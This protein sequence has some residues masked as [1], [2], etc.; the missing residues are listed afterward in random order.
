VDMLVVV[1]LGNPGRKYEATRHNAGYLLADA[2]S[3]HC[4]IGLK[5]TSC[6]A[7][8]GRG[9]WRGCDL[10]I[11][12]P[13]TYMNLSGLAVL[14]L[15]RSFNCSPEHLMVACDDASLP[16]GQIRLRK[17]GSSGGQKGLQ[18]IIDQLGT[19]EFSRLRLGIGP[20]PERMP[21]EDYVLE[22]FTG[23]EMPVVEEMILRARDA[24]LCC[25][26]KGIAAAMGRYNQRLS[27]PEEMKSS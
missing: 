10:V 14:E 3:T 1:A 26:E 5:Q 18:S 22:E 12:K 27:P 15:L 13:T 20:Q 6:H 9:R 11:A 17:S 19:G 24:V 2:L 21:L 23:E 4:R 25:M 16:L 7:V 8:Y